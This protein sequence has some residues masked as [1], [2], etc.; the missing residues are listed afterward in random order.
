MFRLQVWGDSSAGGSDVAFT[1]FDESDGFDSFLSMTA[2]PDAGKMKRSD[3]A[4]S[5]EAPDFSVVIK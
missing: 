5:D 4:D 3:S 1:G 2:P